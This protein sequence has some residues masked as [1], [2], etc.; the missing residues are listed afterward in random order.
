VGAAAGVEEIGAVVTG[1]LAGATTMG[2]GDRGDGAAR[3]DP[4]GALVG[5]PATTTGVVEGAGAVTDGG[6]YTGA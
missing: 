4:A 1:A 6:G 5:P 3:G 2:A